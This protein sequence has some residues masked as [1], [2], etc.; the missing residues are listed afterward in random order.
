MGDWGGL[1][2]GASCD[3]GAANWIRHL[4]VRALSPR[5]PLCSMHQRASARDNVISVEIPWSCLCYQRDVMRR[6][7]TQIEL[8]LSDVY[9]P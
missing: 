8:T 3:Y 5:W 7:L 4:V 6:C 1:E 9:T 2:Y